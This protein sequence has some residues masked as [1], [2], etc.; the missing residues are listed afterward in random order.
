[1]TK[2]PHILPT[3]LLS[4]QPGTVPLL[5][6]VTSRPPT[7]R[8]GASPSV[9]HPTHGTRSRALLC[10][11]VAPPAEGSEDLCAGDEQLCAACGETVREGVPEES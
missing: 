7:G 4:V 2:Q 8:R 3:P 5:L 9:A 11:V 6:V 1:M 10:K